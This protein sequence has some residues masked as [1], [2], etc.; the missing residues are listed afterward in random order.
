MAIGASI[1]A[2]QASSGAAAVAAAPTGLN[3]IS[4]TREY[5]AARAA[6]I[7]KFKRPADHPEAGVAR[8]PYVHHEPPNEAPS[9]EFSVTN[10]S[11]SVTEEL[12]SLS[13]K[14]EKLLAGGITTNSKNMITELNILRQTVGRI[15]SMATANGNEELATDALSLFQALSQVLGK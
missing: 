5:L 11:S 13:E 10:V 9:D 7:P 14:A 6:E 3:G 2:G 8:R 15:V 1:Q 12:T 4:V